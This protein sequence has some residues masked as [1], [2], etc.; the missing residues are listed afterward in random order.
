MRCRW[1]RWLAGLAVLVC[2]G[3]SRADAGE[4]EVWYMNEEWYDWHVWS[5][6]ASGKIGVLH[7][8]VHFVGPGAI[9]PRGVYVRGDADAPLEQID[10]MGIRD[11]AGQPWKCEPVAIEADGTPEGKKWVRLATG[12]NRRG[13]EPLI[14]KVPVD[15]AKQGQV[16]DYVC[17]SPNERY[18]THGRA[19]RWIRDTERG[20]EVRCGMPLGGIGA[21]KV[22]IARDGWFRNI[23]T[24]N[25]IDAPFYHPEYCF[26]FASVNDRLRLLRDEPAAG[27]PKPV[28]DI[29]FEGRY[30]VA[31]MRFSDNDWPVDIRLKAWSPIIP[32]NVDDSSLPVA[33]FEYTLENDTTEAINVHVGMSWENLLGQTGRPQPMGTWGKTGHYYRCREDAGNVTRVSDLALL[34][35]LVFEGDSKKDPDSEG[36]QFLGVDRSA[37]PGISCRIIPGYGRQVV[38]DLFDPPASEDEVNPPAALSAHVVVQ[39]G[40]KVTIPFI[41]TWYLHHFYQM[42]KEDLGHY[43]HNRFKNAEEV[44]EYVRENRERLWRETKAL[45]DLFDA[46]DLPAWTRD[47]L[48]NDLYVLSTDT[49][50]TRDGRFSVNEGATNMYGV[51]GTMDQKLYASHNLALLFPS[52][53]M[54]EL[55]HFGELQNDNGGITHDLGAGQF[56]AKNKAFD[57]PDLC[58]AFSILSYQVYRYSGDEAFWNEIRPKIVKAI[59]CLAADWDPDD[60]GVPGRGSTFDDEDSYRIFSYTTGLYLCDLKLGM[61]IAEEIRDEKLRESY[62]KRYDRAFELAMKE[63]WTGKYFRY[64][65]SPPPEN[66]RTDASHFS[67]MAGE[68]WCRLLDLDGIFEPQVRNAALANTFRLHWNDNFKLPPKIVTPDGKLFPRDDEHRNAPVS[69]PMHSRA[70]MCGSGF[71]FGME[72]QGWDLLRDMRDNIIAANGPDPWDQSLYWDPITARI[73]WGVFYMTAPA[74]W[75]AYQALTDTYYDAVERRLTFRPEAM[76]KVQPGKFPI[77]TTKLW[78]TGEVSQDS[79]DLVIAVDRLISG[80][81]AIRSIRI[82]DDVNVGG[83]R[84]DGQPVPVRVHGDVIDLGEPVIPRPG[85]R[86]EIRLVPPLVLND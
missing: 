50:L 11:H 30:P 45:H 42:G 81:V 25:N 29:E 58:S 12:A 78:A 77:I 59:E 26:A 62:Q 54:Q 3:T 82:A 23:T 68:F 31:H 9:T 66:K 14:L 10:V 15:A 84:V 85:T 19:E 35:G 60:T 70:L 69:W 64:G 61:K 17:V 7:T 18:I 86:I 73:D 27:L 55:R 4:H 32:G 49:W 21:G 41:L 44:A 48:L 63:L 57:W 33:I 1:T 76:A 13:F 28:H 75:L 80:V 53:Q 71:Y 47:M 51:M 56:V 46:S 39:P 37:H 20:K 83:V 24:N 79:R 16:F 2:A 34:R 40:E 36:N 67:Q 5:D 38:G 72:Q 74:S 43:Y 65:S 8:E 6:F 22:E 52:L